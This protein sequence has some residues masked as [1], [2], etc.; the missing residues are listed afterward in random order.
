MKPVDFWSFL[1]LDHGPCVTIWPGAHLVDTTADVKLEIH[2]GY[3]LPKR[4]WKP[5]IMISNKDLFF[6]LLMEEI[7]NNH[8]ACMKPCNSWEDLPYQLV[9][10]PVHFRVKHPWFPRVYMDTKF[11]QEGPLRYNIGYNHHKLSYTW[12]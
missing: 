11:V 3:T 5:Q 2:V 1:G 8:L 7:P 6:L 4:R 12:V 9:S 10:L